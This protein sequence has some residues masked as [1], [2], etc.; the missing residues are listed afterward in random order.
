MNVA[1][2]E[3]E[4][5]GT[6]DGSSLKSYRFDWSSYNFGGFQKIFSNPPKL[7]ELHGFNAIKFHAI[8]SVGF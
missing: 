5:F 7:F 8:K 4:V 6:E 3:L 2:L 1:I